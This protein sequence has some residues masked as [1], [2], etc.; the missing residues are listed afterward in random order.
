MPANGL[1]AN[2]YD[3]VALHSMWGIFL[4]RHIDPLEKFPTSSEVPH[5]RRHYHPK[6]TLITLAS[7]SYLRSLVVRASAANW[8]LH[9]IYTISATNLF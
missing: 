1:R 9:I 4:L 5:V 8:L 7:V 2:H 3:F 6:Y